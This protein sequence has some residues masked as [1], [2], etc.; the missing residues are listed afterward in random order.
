MN[1]LQVSQRKYDS[2][3]DFTS[4]NDGRIRPVGFC[5]GWTEFSAPPVGQFEWMALEHRKQVEAMLPLKGRFHDDGHATR[6]EAVECYR[7]YLLAT[8]VR[9]ERRERPAQEGQCEAV[10]EPGTCCAAWTRHQAHVDGTWRAFLC[11]VHLT[12]EVVAALYKGFEWSAT[13]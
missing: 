6:A 10:I 3:F 4:R 12:A 9:L 7:Q 11:E 13:S 1:Y 2:R 8:S 5:V